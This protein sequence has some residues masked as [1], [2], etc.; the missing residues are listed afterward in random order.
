MDEDTTSVK[1]TI[2]LEELVLCR[3]R[4]ESVFTEHSC[5]ISQLLNRTFEFILI[6]YEPVSD[7]QETSYAKME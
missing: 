7:W 1:I 3:Q 2:D 6:L 4:P 5:F